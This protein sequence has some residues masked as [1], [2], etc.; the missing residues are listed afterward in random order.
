MKK[1]KGGGGG[2][3]RTRKRKRRRRKKE[4]KDRKRE[5][6]TTTVLKTIQKWGVWV[7]QLVKLPTLH[8]GSGHDLMVHE[9]EPHLRLHADSTEPDW[10]SSF[11]R[12]CGC[13]HM[14]AHT[15]SLSLKINKL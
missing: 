15:H 14:H 10:D 3:R 11:P 1:K 8:F 13:T 6:N 4:K 2:R 5:R 12:L 7:A 9:F